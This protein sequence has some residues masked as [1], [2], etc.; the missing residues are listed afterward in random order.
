MSGPCYG[1]PPSRLAALALQDDGSRFRP[2]YSG[3][4]ILGSLLLFLVAIGGKLDVVIAVHG[5]V[6]QVAV[7]IHGAMLGERSRRGPTGHRLVPFR[8]LAFDLCEIVD[9]EAEM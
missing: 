2:P 3:R 4:R 8:E 9:L 6:E 1:R 5:N 7:R